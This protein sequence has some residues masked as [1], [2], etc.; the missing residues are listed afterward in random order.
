MSV[1]IS[2]DANLRSWKTGGNGFGWGAPQSG[3]R[4]GRRRQG[5]G[6]LGR[7]WSP[8]PDRGAGD[9]R[10]AL[11]GGRPPSR[12]QPGEDRWQSGRRAGRVRRVRTHWRSQR[13]Q[14]SRRGAG[15]KQTL[16]VRRHREQCSSHRSHGNIH[17]AALPRL[18][19]KGREEMSWSE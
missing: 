19:L 5:E 8:R 18:C 17:R 6:N 12:V 13:E 2:R 4:Q 3:R 14:H 15:A 16:Q 9:S 10:P 1:I 11:G 7:W